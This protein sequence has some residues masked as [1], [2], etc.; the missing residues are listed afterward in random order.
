MKS[1]SSLFCVSMLVA[2]LA[3]SIG[4]CKGSGGDTITAIPHRKVVQFQG[5]IDP[6]Y[7]GSWKSKSGAQLKLDKDGTASIVSTAATPHGTVSHVLSGKWLL[8]GQNLLLQYT[9]QQTVVTI[10]SKAELKGSSLTLIQ[11][12]NHFKTIYFKS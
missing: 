7:V 10:Q 11:A 9:Q 2:V 8:S 3:A 12:G 5:S 6:Q 1:K 4:G